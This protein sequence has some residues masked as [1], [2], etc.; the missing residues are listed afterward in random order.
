[1]KKIIKLTENDLI[2]LVNKVL[3]EQVKKTKGDT[4]YP[5]PMPKRP[6]PPVV[7]P[8]YSESYDEMDEGIIH[9]L[10]RWWWEMKHN[11]GHRVDRPTNESYDEMYESDLREGT[12]CTS[13]S[14]CQPDEY[15]GIG[16]D[17]VNGL[18]RLK[19]LYRAPR[20][21]GKYSKLREGS[22]A[23]KYSPKWLNRLRDAVTEEEEMNE[24]GKCPEGLIRCGSGCCPSRFAHAI[25][26]IFKDWY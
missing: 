24:L 19:D 22:P 16:G 7:G 2:N 26:R 11:Q 25:D 6:K 23:S 1:M 20:G 17:G 9:D 3:S 10:K 15:C 8:T 12:P 13:N 21:G 5:K 4:G 18:C 14:D